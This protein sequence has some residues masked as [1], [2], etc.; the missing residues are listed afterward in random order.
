[1]NMG[2]YRAVPDEAMPC[3]VAPGRLIF[4]QIAGRQVGEGSQVLVH[5]A[6][7]DAWLRNGWV[8]VAEQ[9]AKAPDTSASTKPRRSRRSTEGDN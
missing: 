3:T 8:I 1:M 7:V 2:R 5:P 6:L 9:Q 4:D